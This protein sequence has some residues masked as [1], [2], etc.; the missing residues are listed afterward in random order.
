MKCRVPVLVVA[1]ALA[2]IAALLFRAFSHPVPVERLNR[3]RMGMTQDEVRTALGPPTK[4][5][6]GQWTYERPLV[7]GFVNIHWR[8]DGTYD[9]EFNFER[10]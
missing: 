1:I 5:Y 6:D 4:I 9:G 8:E 10:F 2:S 3:L 7:C